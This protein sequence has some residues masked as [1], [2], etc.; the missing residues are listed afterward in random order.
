MC[1]RDRSISQGCLQAAGKPHQL[2][3]VVAAAILLDV[4]QRGDEAVDTETDRVRKVRVE[5][6]KLEDAV[7]GQIGGVNLAV[8]LERSAGA[9]KANP[10]EV[11][12]AVMR[13]LG[14]FVSVALIELEQPRG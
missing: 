13:L 2:L 7:V 14:R 8:G 3:G 12:E 9:E 1:I 11:F 6:E 5:Q 4:A 10:L